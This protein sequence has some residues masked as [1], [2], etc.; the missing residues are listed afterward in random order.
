MQHQRRFVVD[1]PR[2]VLALGSPGSGRA[3]LAELIGAKFALPVVVLDRERRSEAFD[4]A[5]WRQRVAD[6]ANVNAW[7]MMGNDPE[8]LDCPVRRA[9]WLLFLDMPMSMCL[10]RILRYAFGGASKGASGDLEGG[11]WRAIR[12]IWEFPTEIAPH[13]TSVIERE[14]RNRTIFILHS[15]RDVTRFLA[16]LPDADGSSTD[17][18]EKDVPPT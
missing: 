3:R 18:S 10:M 17:S 12:Q 13:V 15:N 16:K 11:V 14:R 8:S 2:R 7:V 1:P 6:L 4:D 5:G 9:D